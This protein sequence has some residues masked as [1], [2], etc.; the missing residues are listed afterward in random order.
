MD[1]HDS[2]LVLI[3][4]KEVGRNVNQFDWLISIKK[5][6]YCIRP[7]NQT[8]LETII[9]KKISRTQLKENYLFT[10]KA[11]IKLKFSIPFWF[12]PFW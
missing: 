2:D 12:Y 5:K 8:N 1:T 3:K 4:R 9:R 11:V 6:S 7:G 10:G